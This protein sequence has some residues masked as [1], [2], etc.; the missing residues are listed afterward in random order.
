MNDALKNEARGGNV[1]LPS[2][3]LLIAQLIECWRDS[4]YPTEIRFRIVLIPNTVELGD[5]GNDLR[6]GAHELIDQVSMKFELL[7]EIA[8][9]S[10]RDEILHH[11][12]GLLL[13]GSE[14]LAVKRFQVVEVPP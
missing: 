7:T 2:C 6:L 14:F 10:S 8:L 3:S 5:E 12:V 11:P 1:S 13:G 9:E 4:S